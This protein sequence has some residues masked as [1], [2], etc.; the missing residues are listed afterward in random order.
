MTLL[1]T[2][3]I[4]VLMGGQSSE[5][6]ISLRSGRAALA[7]LLRK[8]Y[9]AVPIDVDATVCS[10]L[11]DS[12]ADLAFIALHGLGGED[13]TIQG[14]LEVLRIPYTG[15][16]VKACAVA[17]DKVMTKALLEHHGIPVPRGFVRTLRERSR[18]LPRGFRWPVVVKP[19]SEGSTLGVTIVKT[20]REFAAGLKSAFQYGPSVMVE[21]YI[22]GRELTVGVLNDRPL[23]VVEIV[24]PHG[25]YD[26]AAKYTVGASTYTAPAMLSAPVTKL[27]QRL[28]LAVH[29]RLGC[30][31]ATRVDFRLDGRGR[32]FVLEINTV[33]GLTET[34]LLPM[35]AK[36]AGLSYEAL[37]EAMLRS[38][39]EREFGTIK[40]R[41]RRA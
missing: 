40:K 17:M 1:T 30:Q 11:Q 39:V 28:A 5:R 16:G 27:L 7:A 33:P 2:K 24:A 18:T 3:R 19:V 14:L 36:A 6:D 35:A 26:Y 38:A 8:G 31:G 15:S 9:D 25:F 29:Q 34:S 22:K 12:K 10:R 23:P 37:V 32:P 13:G 20:P 41:G 4:A 21:E